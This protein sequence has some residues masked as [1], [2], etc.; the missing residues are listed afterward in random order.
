M[1]RRYSVEVTL[2]LV[3]DLPNFG[4][5]HCY[6]PKIWTSRIKL[7]SSMHMPSSMESIRC[8]CFVFEENIVCL[9]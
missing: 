1:M 3:N 9:I 5:E 6:G 8:V 4:L 7:T 2:L